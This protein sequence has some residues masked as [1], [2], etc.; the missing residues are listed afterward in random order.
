MTHASATAHGAEKSLS[1]LLARKGLSIRELSCLYERDGF[2]TLG[3]VF[4]DSATLLL[5]E[6][7]DVCRIEQGL[8][9]D[10]A[11]VPAPPSGSVASGFALD[12]RVVSIAAQLL[13]APPAA[14]GVTYLCK[15]ART[16]LPALWHQDGAPWAARLSGS[17]ALTI[18][19]ALDDTNTNNG[20]L[21]VIPGS[22]RCGAQSLRPNSLTASMFGLEMDT[23]FVDERSAIELPL[24]S[25]HGLVHHPNVIHGSGPNRSTQ[26]RQALAIGYRSR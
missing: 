13:D 8:S 5:L 24:E 25:G 14:F 11:I 12:Q 19:I 16:G 23:A 18:W 22:H 1:T 20:C 21:R 7:L 26:P 4:D 17:P 15:P 3:E 6:Y 9:A 2:A 10:A